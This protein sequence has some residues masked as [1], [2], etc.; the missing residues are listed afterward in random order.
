M[1]DFFVGAAAVIAAAAAAAAVAGA[2]SLFAAPA[3][4]VAALIARKYYIMLNFF[5]GAA[6]VATVAAAVARKYCTL[7]LFYSKISLR[8]IMLN[9]FVG[10]AAVADAAAPFAAVAVAFATGAAAAAA[11][12]APITRKYY[13]QNDNMLNFLAA[14]AALAAYAA[15]AVV[16]LVAGTDAS[17]VSSFAAGAAIVA[18]ATAVAAGHV[19]FPR[20]NVEKR[21]KMI[22][23]LE[24]ETMRQTQVK[25]LEISTDMAQAQVAKQCHDYDK[26]STSVE[27][28]QVSFE[29]R[30]LKYMYDACESG[31][32][33]KCFATHEKFPALL[34]KNSSECLLRIA[35]SGN[36]D[37][38]IAVESVLLE[39]LG[40]ERQQYIANIV[41]ADNE[42]MLHK[43]C[44]SGSRDMYSYLCN[45]YPSLVA[46]TD[47]STLLQLTC[48]LNKADIMSLLLPSVKD[49]NDIGKCLTQYTLDDRCKKAVALEL[50]QRLADKVKLQGSYRIEPTFNSVGEVVFLAYGSNVVRGRVEQFAGMIVLFRNPKN[51]N[52]EGTRVA[53]SAEMRSL[54]TNNSK[55]ITYAAYKAIEMHGTRLMQSHSNI[56]A[57]GVSHLKSRKE[58]KDLKLAET[59]LVV[60]YCSSKG[61]RPIQEDVFPHQLLVDGIAVFTDVRKGFFEI[62]PRTYSAIPSSHFH[63]KLKMG[64]E[65]DVEEDGQSRGGTIGPFVKIHSRKDGVLDG[66]L[67]CAHVAY[68]FKEVEDSY[69]YD[70]INTP[71]QLQVN[72]PALNTFMP[73]KSINIDSKC[74]RTYRG[75]YGVTVDG[76]TV[77]AAVVAVENDRMPSGGEFAFVRYNQLAEIGFK[78]F[79]VFDSADQ[80]EP[81]AIMNEEIVKF[82]AI[83]HATKGVYVS[84]VHVRE[85][86]SVRR[87]GLTGLTDR[88][89]EMK[90]Q[91][92]ISSCV[93]NEPF[94]A[95]G[96]SGSG[97]FVKRGDDL[98]CLGLGIGCLSNGSAVVTPIKPILKA[99]GVELMRFTEPVDDSQ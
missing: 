41:D 10:T 67:T 75:T 14:V 42:S 2:A 3:A 5:D 61:L 30:N 87:A 91:L 50:K 11:V 64:C 58:G 20:K 86:I 47:T 33:D 16:D 7:L 35:K 70:E 13:P 44:R 98:R 26:G 85:P 18:G 82:G 73:S 32:K 29:N 4:A 37:C 52:D 1:Q 25:K 6:A 83:T 59:A 74:G 99:L 96:D 60:I 68:G 27:R 94:F 62:A 9:S 90:G 66:F 56:N 95:L 43:A 17:F 93:S 77:D 38:F 57:L 65:C 19:L 34:T 63:P 8:D 80:A 21:K 81:T 45:T 23:E 24:I 72:Q 78:T 53:N 31:D 46:S 69:S 92:E 15:A 48:E 88:R 40:E 12:V 89:F 36:K 79:P 84:L 55:G 28:E 49:E 54:E 97:V 71:T 22:A 76:V 39:K 51:V